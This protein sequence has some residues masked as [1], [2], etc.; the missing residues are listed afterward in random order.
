[1]G[2]E[3]NLLRTFAS[4]D[5]SDVQKNAKMMRFLVYMEAV[6]FAFICGGLELGVSDG[7]GDLM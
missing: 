6:C 4:S 3:K 2:E 1:L 7:G 5:R